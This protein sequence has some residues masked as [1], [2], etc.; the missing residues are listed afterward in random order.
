VSLEFTQTFGKRLLADTAHT[1]EQFA[2]TERTSLKVPDRE[3]GPLAADQAGAALGGMILRAH[4]DSIGT[5]W[6]PS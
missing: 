1:A 2:V 6:C 4:T 5:F 3:S